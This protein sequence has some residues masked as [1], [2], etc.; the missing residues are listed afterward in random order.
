M[1][2]VKE[3]ERD[4]RCGSGSGESG[5]AT[6]EEEKEG[7]GVRGT[8]LKLKTPLAALDRARRSPPP[9]S[10]RPMRASPF[11][12]RLTSAPTHPGLL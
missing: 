2:A 12:A 10:Y 5:E 4:A 9:P 3:R 8:I 11:I 6:S 1:V 7:G